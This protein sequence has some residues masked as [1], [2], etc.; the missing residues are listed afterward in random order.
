[1]GGA[2]H[3]YCKYL[4]R[5]CKER[6]MWQ[7]EGSRNETR[8]ENLLAWKDRKEYDDISKK[9]ELE[10]NSF[11]ISEN[12][13]EHYLIVNQNDSNRLDVAVMGGTTKTKEGIGIWVV[14]AEGN[15]VVACAMPE[16][17]GGQRGLVVE[18][19]KFA[20]IKA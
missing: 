13:G 10:E 12:L 18:S 9:Q 6:N 5:L 19:V 20:L 4:W 11:Q 16:Q 8:K 3:T 2:R 17:R 1:M 15:A 14:N 7:F